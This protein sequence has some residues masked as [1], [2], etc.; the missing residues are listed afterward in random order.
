MKRIAPECFVEIFKA[1]NINIQSAVHPIYNFNN[2]IYVTKKCANISTAAIFPIKP[3]TLTLED[4]M[5]NRL[6]NQN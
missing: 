4:R 1:S 5:N 2:A 3:S 6:N